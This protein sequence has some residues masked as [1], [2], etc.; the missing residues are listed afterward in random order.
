MEVRG[1]SD[2][3]FSFPPKLKSLVYAGTVLNNTSTLRYN[4]PAPALSTIYAIIIIDPSTPLL[5]GYY[6]S[7]SKGPACLYVADDEAKE[8]HQRSIQRGRGIHNRT[9]PP[10]SQPIAQTCQSSRPS[11]FLFCHIIIGGGV[12]CTIPTNTNNTPSQSTSRLPP[13]GGWIRS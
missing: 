3:N 6:S 8:I 12:R 5:H 1:L 2:G 11:A 13:L 7:V 10:I 4:S 9:S